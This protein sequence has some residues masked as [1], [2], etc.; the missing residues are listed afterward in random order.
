MNANLLPP[1]FIKQIEELFPDE[2]P[3]LLD[4]IS[5]TEAVTSIRVNTAKTQS[6][7]KNADRVPWCDTGYYLSQHEQFTFDP[8]F[9]AGLYY[10]QDASSMII[11]YIIKSLINKPIKYLDL[12][13][14]PGGKSTAALSALPAGSLMVCNEIMPQRANILKENIIKWGNPNC[15][16]TNADSRQFG[17]LSGFF[18]VVAT[19]VPCS[20]EGMFRKDK[21]AIEQW[22]PSLVL[23]C[24]ERQRQIIDNIWDAIAPGGLLIYSTCTFNRIENESIIEYIETNY[25][26]TPIT[27][28]LPDNWGISTGVDHKHRGCYRFFPHRTRGEGLFICILQKNEAGLKTRPIKQQHR[29]NGNTKIPNEI[30]QWIIDNDRYNFMVTGNVITAINSEMI[31]DFEYIANNVKVMLRGVEVGIIK[32]KDIIPAQSI[33][34]STILNSFQFNIVEIDYNEAI[35]Y[36]RGDT[37]SLGNAPRGVVLLQ[38]NGIPLGFAK[39]LGN[40][41][42]NLYPKEWRIR[43]T[44]TPVKPPHI[45][46]KL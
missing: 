4:T 38:Y 23:Q 20:G 28:V 22:S 36:L 9:H 14:A 7:P 17:R 41:A 29:T 30:K 43:S 25:D 33:A 15:I 13:A 11:H 42:N 44:H 24:A 46:M 12:C 31:H 5:G 27:L 1:L 35:A 16:V 18:D 10:V 26:A 6:V 32:G 2:C 40:R 3:L 34:L 19:D 21:M 37:I 39:Q 8:A 45:E